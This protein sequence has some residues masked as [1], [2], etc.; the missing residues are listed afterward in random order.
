M[1]E[2]EVSLTTPTLVY[3]ARHGETLWN[4]ERRFQGHLDS[5]LTARGVEQARRLGQRLAA[6]PLRAVYSSD[7]GRT[8]STAEQVA[9][10]HGLT[11]QPHQFL[12]EIDTGEWTGLD[13][14]A[15]RDH[16]T[17][18]PLLDDYRKRPWLAR[19]PKG[20]TVGEVQQRGLAFLKEIAPRHA[21]QAIAVVAHHVVVETILAHAL[22]VP[23]EGLW[24]PH[25]GGN[26]F[27]SLLEVTPTT[28]LPQVVY[29]GSHIGDLAGLDGTKGEPQAGA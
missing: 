22:G 8:V 10:P 17:W 23:L 6:E 28:M 7:L 9:T 11:V 19:L 14:D 25:R 21:G 2:S 12:R 13:R 15:V 16:P 20:E 29:D 1:F 26:C 27:L 18:G 24:L 3:L 5:P 4:T